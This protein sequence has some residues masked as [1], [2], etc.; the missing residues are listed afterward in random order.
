MLGIESPPGEAKCS[1]ESALLKAVMS[2]ELYLTIRHA[3]SFQSV[4][5]QLLTYHWIAQMMASVAVVNMALKTTY[6]CRR[7]TETGVS[8]HELL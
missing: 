3:R 6:A 4:E 1:K 2:T 5:C 8:N 7:G